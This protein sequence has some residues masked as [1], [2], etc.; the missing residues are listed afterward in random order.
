[1]AWWNSNNVE[2]GTIFNMILMSLALSERL[3]EAKNSAV[4]FA[5]ESEQKA[6]NLAKEMTLELE[7][8]KKMLE[9]AL[10]SERQTGER[11][12]RFLSMIS[13]EY[14][15]PLAI[16][17]T[18]I[19]LLEC[20][21]NETFTQLSVKTDKM[22]RAVKRLVEIMEISLQ[23]SELSNAHEKESF[24]M[25]HV[26]PMIDNVITDFQTLWPE[27]SVLYSNT[28][29]LLEIY[30]NYHY[31]ET[32]VLNLLDNARKY[33]LPYTVI[34]VHCKTDGDEVVIRIH[35][36]CKD[37][38][39]KEISLLFGKYH[40]GTNSSGTTGTGIG[41]WFVR[42]IIDLHNGTISIEISAGVFIG[43]VRLPFTDKEQNIQNRLLNS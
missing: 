8:N 5:K 26:T 33:S 23:R 40:Q 43:T 34:N 27:H 20:E 28:L 42:L 3:R 19:D 29:A 2:F 24:Q 36:Q 22:K 12:S 7:K 31:L 10:A 9:I 17:C 35:N 30:G 1:M 38:S 25:F 41:L 15:T 37:I 39:P 16:I 11:K 18:N 21:E 32:V 14:R 6:V 4:Q 13:H